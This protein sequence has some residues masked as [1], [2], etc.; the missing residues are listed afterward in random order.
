MHFNKVLNVTYCVAALMFGCILATGADQPKSSV[1]LTD[2]EVW[3]DMTN[4]WCAGVAWET[5]SL[6]N[7]IVQNVSIAI[8]TSKTNGMSDYFVPPKKKLAKVELRDS[9]GMLLVPL[10]GKNLVGELPQQ[11]LIKDWPRYPADP[12]PRGG[13][14]VGGLLEGRL[15]LAPN[16][17]A[18]PWGFY[19]QDMY[20]IEKEGDY[21]FTVC[22]AIYHFTNDKQSVVRMDLP[23]VSIPMRLT[24]SHK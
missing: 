17:L 24:P 14:G 12:D 3:G 9:Q 5:M 7:R 19:M 4:Q 2:G 15:F 21:T 20:R 8:K 1:S 22:M 11:I 10:K 23:C 18:V 6:G 16:S 13:R